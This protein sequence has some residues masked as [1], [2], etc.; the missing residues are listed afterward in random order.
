MPSVDKDKMTEA[1]KKEVIGYYELE[2][3]L[4]A[5]CFHAR[6]QSFLY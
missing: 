5:T 1:N 3:V 4:S 6:E 2:V